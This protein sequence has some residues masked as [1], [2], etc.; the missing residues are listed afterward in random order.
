[1]QDEAI[2]QDEAMAILPLAIGSSLRGLG[3]PEQ[4]PNRGVKAHCK[5]APARSEYL[6]Q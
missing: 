4:V 3:A 1:M 6:A 5:I 2:M